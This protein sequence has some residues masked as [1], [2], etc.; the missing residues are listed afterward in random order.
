M[1]RLFTKNATGIAPDGRWFAGDI[2][3]LQDAVA[4]L[5]DLSQALGVG[6]IQIGESGLQLLRYGA[7]E[8]RISGAL[9]TDGIVRALGGLYAGAFT[10][11]LRDAIPVNMAPYGLVILNTTTN[12]YEWNAGTDVARDWRPLGGVASTANTLA[13]IPAA[14]AG[15]VGSFFYATDQDVLYRSTGSAWVRISADHPGDLKMTL[16]AAADTG[17]VLCAGQAWPSTTGIYA[18]L[19]AK[20]GGVYPTVLPDLR[21]RMPVNIGTHADINAIG[22][23]E[24]EVTVG[25]RRPKHKHTLDGGYKLTNV[26]TGTGYAGGGGD[27]V[28]ITATVGPQAASPTDA[29]AYYTVNFEAKL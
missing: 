17:R 12:L 29:P 5:N 18:A 26:G 23:T 16:N 27:G 1:I 25:N 8:A 2:N 11:T 9:R 3:A 7:G 15:N 28:P 22:A 13:N 24:G 10:T 21:G 19:F 4:A 6:S 20:W 14:V